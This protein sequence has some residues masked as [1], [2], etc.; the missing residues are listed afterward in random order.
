MTTSDTSPSLR[1]RDIK[2]EAEATLAA[3]YGDREAKAMVRVIFEDVM[4]WKPVD[5]ILKADYELTDFSARRVADIVER[6]RA[7]EPIQ[8][9]VGWADFCGMRFKVTRDTLIPRP[10]TAELVDLIVKEMHDRKDLRVLDCGTGS[11]CIAIAL[12]CAL[13]FADVEGIDISDA[14]LKVAAANAAELRASARFSHKDMLALT[15]PS[16][17]CYDIIVSNPP[18][19]AQSERAGMEQNVLDYEP[20]TA[21]FVPDDDPLRFYHAVTRYAVRALTPGGR[22]YFEINPL[23]ADRL[24]RDVEAAGMHSVALERDDRGKLRFLTATR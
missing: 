18:Y 15:P 21:L 24:Q 14:A 3:V 20:A 4:G 5:L 2:A 17:P 13:P 22:L 8:Q 19:I 10:E 6:V 12:A 11:G 23:Y 16:A 9:V 1:V 7:G